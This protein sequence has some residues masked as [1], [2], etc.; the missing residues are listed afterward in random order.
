MKKRY[1]L[2]GFIL[3][4][5]VGTLLKDEVL[6]EKVK[7]HFDE[8]PVCICDKDV[9]CKIRLQKMVARGSDIDDCID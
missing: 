4:V 5:K 2:A 3:G 1:I 8:F 7:K 6:K 9:C